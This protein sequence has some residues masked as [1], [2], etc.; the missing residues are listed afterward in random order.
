M[1][2][3]TRLVGIC[4]SMI[5]VI[6]REVYLRR[7]ICLP[8]RH[9][10]EGA[11]CNPHDGSSLPGRMRKQVNIRALIVQAMAYIAVFTV[12][13]SWNF[14]PRNIYEQQLANFKSGLFFLLIQGFFNMLIF[15]FHKI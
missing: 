1:L 4:L 3:I 6:S 2:I 13:L 5:L 15:I 11:T 9:E 8:S 7:L 14:I 12:G 10:P